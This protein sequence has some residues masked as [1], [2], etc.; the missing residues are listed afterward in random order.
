MD[1]PE[2][3]GKP[4]SH[5]AVTLRL[6]KA[7]EEGIVYSR[8]WRNSIPKVNKLRL[9]GYE[10]TLGKEHLLAF[11]RFV[12][13]SKYSLFILETNGMI[14]GFDNNYVKRLAK[15][16]EKLYVRVSFKAVTRRI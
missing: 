7:T 1:F 15:F 5:K 10:P 13:E 2:K 6:F 16:K 4:Y 8:Y 3:F 11:L 12:K 9:S 14:L